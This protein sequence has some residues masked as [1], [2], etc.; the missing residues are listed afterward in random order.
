[1]DRN[2]GSI[3]EG[4]N[5]NEGK[6]ETPLQRLETTINERFKPTWMRNEKGLETQLAIPISTLQIETLIEEKEIPEDLESLFAV[7]NV[8][9]AHILRQEYFKKPD[10]KGGIVYIWPTRTCPVGC[11]HCMFGA[12]KSSEA[13]KG[14][15]G[16]RLTNDQ[17]EKAIKFSNDMAA[18][19]VALSGGGEPLEERENV[20]KTISEVTAK[21]IQIITNGYW[22][23]T[24]EEVNIFFEQLKSAFETRRQNG[25]PEAKF[26][27]KLSLDEEHQLHLPLKNIL[28]IVEEYSR[29]SFPFVFEIRLKSIFREDKTV[30]EFLR[31]MQESY[32]GTKVEEI[33]LYK[34]KISLPTGQELLITFKNKVTSGR[35]AVKQMDGITANYNSDFV[36]YVRSQLPSGHI[37]PSFQALGGE[38]IEY[39]G[40]ANFTLEY[41]GSIKLLEATPLDNVPNLDNQ[42]FAEALDLI[43]KDPISYLARLDGPQIIYGIGA[44]IDPDLLRITL[45]QNALYYNLERILNTPR[46]RL[47]AT[48]RSLQII[49]ERHSEIFS[50]S[51]AQEKLQNSPWFNSNPTE[52]AEIVRRLEGVKTVKKKINV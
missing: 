15:P 12:P 16:L 44:E 19:V 48:I 40:G 18:D 31:T 13:L 34:I 37:N 38:N 2:S 24:P 49:N 52:M 22:G 4:L 20:F 7:P 27:L 26:V 46:K 42:D 23:T 35:G 25:L 33:D 43:F 30:D 29:G 8:A 21:N 14:R 6:R 1:M 36:D 17:T 11:A 3:Y 9:R 41:D 10:Y 45:S 32:P 50:N 28:N 51:E 39:E 47:Y 5:R